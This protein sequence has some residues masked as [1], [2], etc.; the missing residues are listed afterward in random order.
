MLKAD[1]EEGE[2]G[3]GSGVTG[4]YLFNPLA[5]LRPTLPVKLNWEKIILIILAKPDLSIYLSIN[6]QSIHLSV[7]L[8]I[9]L[10]VYLSKKNI[11][12]RVGFCTEAR[13]FRS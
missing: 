6:Y 1:E 8:S 7:Y 2:G 13:M 10:S 11:K 4:N 9:Y 5:S 12:Q 3:Q